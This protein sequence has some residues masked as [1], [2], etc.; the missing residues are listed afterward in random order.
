[1]TALLQKSLT[2]RVALNDARSQSFLKESQCLLKRP[3]HAW[4]LFKRISPPDRGLAPIAGRKQ[5][6]IGQIGE[7]AV[8]VELKSV[9]NLA[10]VHS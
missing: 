8:I 6:C 9:E 2:H 4:E 3:A 7:D 10:P 1:M 5:Q